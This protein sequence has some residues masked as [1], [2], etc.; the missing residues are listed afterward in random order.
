MVSAKQPSLAFD[1]PAS[2]RMW[3]FD[4]LAVFAR[5]AWPDLTPHNRAEYVNRSHDA[6]MCIRGG[7]P[8]ADVTEAQ[9][10]AIRTAYEE[11]IG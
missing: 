6:L 2:A 9:R 3:T 7:T 10:E 1:E 5:A 4:E 11:S 8:S